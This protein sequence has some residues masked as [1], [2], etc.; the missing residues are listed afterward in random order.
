MP[1]ARIPAAVMLIQPF[2]DSFTGSE[3]VSDACNQDAR[4]EPR[5]ALN[6]GLGCTVYG[7]NQDRAATA[8][9]I[10]I[11]KNGLSFSSPN[12]LDRAPWARRGLC[13]SC[14]NGIDGAGK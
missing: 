11:S 2:L 4:R 9:I 8:T 10:D 1:Q 5:F 6:Q 7:P 12:F 3:G 13:A 14:R